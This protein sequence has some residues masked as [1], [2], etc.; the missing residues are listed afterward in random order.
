MKKCPYCCAEIDS[1]ALKC[2]FCGEWVE[3][4]QKV[5]RNNPDNDTPA[6]WA[7]SF[8]QSDNL[9]QTL[10]EGIKLYAG[11]KIVASIIGIIIFL[12]FFLGVFLPMF[13]RVGGG[14]HSFPGPSNTTFRIDK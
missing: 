8:M 12:I 7:K 3:A 13:N 2:K 14:S 6:G 11:W 4:P 1:S 5:D 10:N 9:N